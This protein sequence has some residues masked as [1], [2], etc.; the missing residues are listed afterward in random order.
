MSKT[1]KKVLV[2]ASAGLVLGWFGGG[3]C[4]GW[5][6]LAVA[7]A[8]SFFFTGTLNNLGVLAGAGL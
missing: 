7:S 6:W 3:G 1:T 8:A 4:G 5:T 2:L